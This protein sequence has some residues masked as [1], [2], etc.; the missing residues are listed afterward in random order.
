MLLLIL[1]NKYAQLLLVGSFCFTIGSFLGYNK[2]VDSERVIQVKQYAQTVSEQ[3]VRTN[4]ILANKE[5]AIIELTTQKNNLL[6]DL[7][8]EKVSLNS[9]NRIHGD[10]VRL[11]SGSSVSKT[12]SSANAKTRTIPDFESV[13]ADQVSE[14]IIQLKAHDDNCVVMQNSLVDSVI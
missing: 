2:G 4:Q 8:H 14:Y 3:V 9:R 1:R 13:P 7:Q 10:F 11:S 5:S 6:K 12:S